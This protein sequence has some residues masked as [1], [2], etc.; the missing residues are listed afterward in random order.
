MSCWVANHRCGMG[1]CVCRCENCY[2][3]SELSDTESESDG[4]DHPPSDGKSAGGKSDGDGH[5]PSDDK[6]AD[7]KCYADG[8]NCGIWKDYE[9]YEGYP[10]TLR[11]AQAREQQPKGTDLTQMCSAY[12]AES[13]DKFKLAWFMTETNEFLTVS[14]FTSLKRL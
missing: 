2:K 1:S 12:R 6:S 7:D 8:L 14:R 10:P 5:P 3:R 11:T 9:Y 13:Y 4:D